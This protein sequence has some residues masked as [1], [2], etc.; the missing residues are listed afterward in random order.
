M[1]TNVLSE[2]IGSLLRK[3]S[4]VSETDVALTNGVGGV[5]YAVQG[6][7]TLMVALPINTLQV[8]IDMYG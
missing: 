1:Q 6:I 3:D 7:M 8:Y 2:R 5:S 4:I